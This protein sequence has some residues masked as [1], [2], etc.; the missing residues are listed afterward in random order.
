MT[1]RTT[2]RST[3]PTTSTTRTATTTSMTS[4]TS[5]TSTTTSA[6]TPTM[7]STSSTTTRSPTR[8]PQKRSDG[9]LETPL[10]ASGATC[11]PSRLRSGATRR[12]S[13][14]ASALPRASV[15]VDEGDEP[16]A[17][18]DE[19]RPQ[20]PHAP[21][22]HERPHEDQQGRQGDH[23]EHEPRQDRGAV[24]RD[25]RHRIGSPL[26]VAQPEP[27]AASLVGGPAVN[28]S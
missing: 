7:A 9:G 3:R 10:R 27:H 19:A 15:H 5:T 28:A 1:T 20:P 26:L 25:D 18:A 4:S 11:V 12:V 13:K 22:L 23:P 8:Q 21:G 24:I 2:T 14:P 6:T 16:Q 17:D